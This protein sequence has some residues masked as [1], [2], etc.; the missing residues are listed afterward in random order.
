VQGWSALVPVSLAALGLSY[1]LQLAVDDVPLDL[2]ASLVAVGLIV[3]AELAYWSL[4]ERERVEGER[5][6]VARRLAYLALLGLGAFVV[7]GMLLVLVDAVRAGGLAIDLLGAAAAAA[8][9]VAI[10]LAARRTA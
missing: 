2:A 3:I 5:G 10:A 7:A 9:I 1:G 6:A 4:E 8:A